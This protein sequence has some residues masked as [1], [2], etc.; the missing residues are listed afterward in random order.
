MMTPSVLL[1]IQRVVR[2]CNIGKVSIE[3]LCMEVSEDVWIDCLNY[4]TRMSF[5]VPLPVE[6]QQA[7]SITY[8]GVK[9]LKPASLP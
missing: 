6:A 3:G 2:E 1:R 4:I 5:V 7:R 9:I 8:F